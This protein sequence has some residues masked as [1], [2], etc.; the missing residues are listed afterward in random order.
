MNSGRLFRLP[1]GLFSSS[2]AIPMAN[3]SKPHPSN[4]PV[5]N[6]LRQYGELKKF[7]GNG[8]MYML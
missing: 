3:T 5:E 7:S 2:M 4:P 1:N 8:F 6:R